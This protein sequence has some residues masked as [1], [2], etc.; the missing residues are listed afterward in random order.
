MN[1]DC[2]QDGW[3][4]FVAYLYFSKYGSIR[5][6]REDSRPEYNDLTWS[7]TA[8]G[9]SEKL[10]QSSCEHCTEAA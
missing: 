8:S 7:V 2:H 4:L 3:A 10:V 5:L 6:G 1:D 9:S